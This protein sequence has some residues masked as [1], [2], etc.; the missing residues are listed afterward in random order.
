MNFLCAFVSKAAIGRKLLPRPRCAATLL[1]FLAI[2][3]L[4]LLPQVQAA[5]A[6]PVA[7]APSPDPR[8]AD[9]SPRYAGQKVARDSGLSLSLVQA[10]QTALQNNEDIK[11]SFKRV[12]AAEAGV[13]AAKGGYDLNAFS[14]A[15]YGR[16][17]GLTNNDYRPSQQFNA[18]K[19]YARIDSGL[20]QRVPTGGTL[21]AYHTYAHESLLGY[22]ND[23]HNLD[24]NYLT[25]EFTQSLLKGIGDKELRGAIETAMLSVSDSIEAKKLLISQVVLEV[26]RA[27]WTLELSVENL[28]I[29]QE[30]LSMAKRSL[31]RERTRFA[32]GI[33]QGVDVD[34]ASLA[35]RQREYVVLQYER[36]IAVS[37]ERLA[38]LI[39]HPDYNKGMTLNTLSTP[40][41]KVRPMPDK[42]ASLQTALTNRHELK[43]IAIL[44]KQLGIEFDINTNKLLP[45]LDVTAGMTTSNGNDTLRS[46]EQFK[47]TD[48]RH[49]WFVGGAF[50]F[51]LQNREARG[52]RERTSFLIR[53]A[54]DRLQKTT[55]QVD[56]ELNEVLHN[57]VLARDGIPVAR[58]A[59][60]SARKTLA[61]ELHRFE[62]GGVNNRDLLAAQ[63]A[64]GQ[65]KINY[66][67]AIAN[68]NVALAEYEHVC[69][70]L[71]DWLHITVNEESASIR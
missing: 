12:K 32:E 57:L 70:T 53:I 38:M 59:M 3:M 48:E 40:I 11:E 31:A 17:N 55:R 52:N 60:E 69:A 33:S 67:A 16:F 30:T 54:N 26:I 49:S 4:L 47:D 42:V 23:R 41:A 7:S 22:G 61:G 8:G 39:N 65:Q 44:L 36:D 43:Q 10:I 46:A 56:T 50:A 71:L 35:V 66:Q 13:M 34:R 14:N 19:S 20:R 2:F 28:K 62:M 6:V 18:A 21:S 29:A 37:R 27:Y 64:L 24:R 1:G 15:R 9:Y 51:P 45:V 5:D 68:Y 58:T 63:D 25:L